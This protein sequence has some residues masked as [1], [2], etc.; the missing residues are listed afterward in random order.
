[1]P[2]NG[3]IDYNFGY[4]YRA[5]KCVGIPYA[6]R[7]DSVRTSGNLNLTNSRLSLFGSVSYSYSWQSLKTY[8]YD[9]SWI[10]WVG[11]IPVRFGLKIPYFFG[12]DIA[13]TVA[14]AVSLTNAATGNYRFDYT[15]TESR[16]DGSNQSTVQFQPGSNISNGSVAVNVG[17]K[18]YVALEAVGYVVSEWFLS[19]GIGSE[20]SAPS[21]YWGY[22]GNG[23]GDAD[24]DGIDEFVKSSI[25]DVNGQLAL[26]G[27]WQILGHD[28]WDW[29]DWPF[30]VSGWNLVLVNDFSNRG[31]GP[32]VALRRNL[33]FREFQ[34]LTS[35]ALTP[36]IGGSA[37]ILQ[38][39]SG[40]SA[41]LRDCVP[42][43]DR[44]NYV[45]AWGDGTNSAFSGNAQEWTRVSHNYAQT[46]AKTLTLSAITDTLGRNLGPAKT[47]RSITVAL[48]VPPGAP[49][50][51]TVPPSAVGD[52]AVSWRAA[53]GAVET[54]E[55]Q[56]KEN[57]GAWE[58][59]YTG[60]STSF[61][62]SP[63]DSGSQNFQV[64]AG[65][66][67][68]WS[69]YTSSSPVLVRLSQETLAAPV[70]NIELLYAP[71]VNYVRWNANTCAKSYELFLGYTNSATNARSVGSQ[72]DTSR[73]WEVYTFGMPRFVWAKACRGTRC[74][75]FSTS[76]FLQYRER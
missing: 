37:T 27:K 26:Y 1:M 6:F 53:S 75:P 65:N 56:R 70:L 67:T 69:A 41:K 59:V 44:I 22:W 24:G 64:R 15:C 35:S 72:S 20:L 68:G 14:G 23:C 74:G 17:V 18:P 60:P 54:Y 36:M 13:A 62:A 12:Y 30:P 7:F 29:I 2:L 33:L 63:C 11:P 8:L 3:T 45:F 34:S 38:T 57:G 46:G 55:L 76:G 25:F 40:F 58:T 10:V 28:R 19:A 42:L 39:G 47:S 4:S 43:H 21:T 51:I 50:A 32:F 5:N 31:K 48:S 61:L 73:Y 49:A 66:R 71:G 52:F 9:E 16:C